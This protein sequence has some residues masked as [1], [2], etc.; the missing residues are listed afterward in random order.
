MP[1]LHRDYECRSC[2]DI[3]RSAY[4]YAQDPSTEVLCGAYCVDDGPINL[5][6][7]GQAIPGEFIAAANDPEW[8]TCSHNAMFERAIEQFVLK[9]PTAPIRRQRCTMSLALVHGL[10]G[11]LEAV[12]KALFLVNGKD[13]V[14][15]R[16]MLQMAKPRRPHK[17]EDPAGIY[18]F[19]DQERRDRLASY[20]VDDVR[21]ERELYG[22]LRALSGREQLIWQLDAEINARGFGIDLEL[23]RAASR[24]V[25]DALDDLDHDLAR[26]TD[27]VVTRTTQVARLQAWVQARIVRRVESLD[28]ESIEALLKD[29][30]LP[31]EVRR[32]LELRLLSAQA[33]VKKVN[34][35]L[36]WVGA[37]NRVRGCFTY[38]RAGTGRWS[39]RGPQPQN[40]HRLED[41]E[42]I[43][44]AL[45]AIR[46]G[47]YA[48]VKSKFSNP[49][50]LVGTHIRPLV[51]AERGKRLIGADFSGIENRVLAWLAD[52]RWKLEHFRKF[53]A[54]EIAFDNYV[55]A[56][57]R[58]FN[59]S[60]ESVTKAQRQIGKVMELALGFQGGIGAFQSMAAG[61]GV[62]VS[63]AMAD[64]LKCAWRAQHPAIVSFWAALNACAVEAAHSIGKVVTCG[65]VAF[66]REGSYLFLRLP[67]SRKIAYPYPRVIASKYGPAV[68]FK[69]NAKGWQDCRGGQ[70][71]YAGMWCENATQGV[72]RDL[73][74]EALIKLEASTYLTVL[75][76]HDEALCE[77]PDGFGSVDRFR[78]IMMTSP[79]WADGLPI[80]AG[81]W[82]GPAYVK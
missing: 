47:C 1:V 12:A 8:L 25:E 46:T 27:G 18:W 77:V 40:F 37:D 48:H 13:T 59:V 24:I 39:A 9:W 5:W 43:P 42:N 51:I 38:S 75:H 15:R 74:A 4:R 6:L 61:Y 64:Q 28:K 7:P 72:A 3:K 65:K 66:R 32:A 50:E 36:D 70:G 35:L 81:A 57:S 56:Y 44:A 17:D 71:A 52:E 30:S 68:I 16:L 79:V 33:S 54:G 20:C 67:S 55:M 49:L 41:E 73:L 22:R 78:G 62:K 19:E 21:A 26:L 80:A 76:C 29:V 2:V 23:T 14:G 69:D 63:D 58:A 10:P 45:A 53:D 31:S 34:T 11:K 60:P 82:E